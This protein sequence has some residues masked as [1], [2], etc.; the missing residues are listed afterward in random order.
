MDRRAQ[1]DRAMS[2]SAALEE[3]RQSRLAQSRLQAVAGISDPGTMK[4]AG[5]IEAEGEYRALSALYSGETAATSDQFSADVRRREGR[6]ARSAG[7]LA[8]AGT[9]AGGV[10]KM[11]QSFGGG[12]FSAST[13]AAQKPRYMGGTPSVADTA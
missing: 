1:A 9:V 6:E 5:D 11:Y 4:L 3:R 2:Q 10:S 12:G 8:L 13:Y 7:R